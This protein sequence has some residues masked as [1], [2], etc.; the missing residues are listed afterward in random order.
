M[1]LKLTFPAVYSEIGNVKQQLSVTLLDAIFR[2]IN[3]LTLLIE[4]NATA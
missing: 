2:N 1:L 3:P 4:K